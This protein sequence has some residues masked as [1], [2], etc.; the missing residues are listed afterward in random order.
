MV[1]SKSL[2]FRGFDKTR[3][4]KGFPLFYIIDTEIFPPSS[5]NCSRRWKILPPFSSF[6]RK[7]TA[8]KTQDCINHWCGF[9]DAFCGTVSLRQRW[10][11]GRGRGRER[12]NLSVFAHSVMTETLS[13]NVPCTRRGLVLPR[14]KRSSDFATTN[15]QG[16]LHHV[17]WWRTPFILFREIWQNSCHSYFCNCNVAKYRSFLF[18][19]RW[20][21]LIIFV[22]LSQPFVCN[23]EWHTGWENFTLMK[24]TEHVFFVFSSLVE[25]LDLMVFLEYTDQH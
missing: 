4:T 11:L 16:W 10:G 15:S 7:N 8:M 25:A 6:S 17:V 5:I 9:R 24:H 20:R 12:G 14:T 23:F 18:L 19:I 13:V 2:R 3:A 1:V 21:N 22:S